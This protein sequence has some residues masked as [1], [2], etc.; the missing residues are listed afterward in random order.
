MTSSISLWHNLL[1]SLQ[2]Q[3]FNILPPFTDTYLPLYGSLNYAI[4]A[5]FLGTKVMGTAFETTD[6]YSGLEVQGCGSA[7]TIWYITHTSILPN[8]LLTNE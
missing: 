1:L 4:M 7:G 8:P 6:R 5:T 3:Q 2:I